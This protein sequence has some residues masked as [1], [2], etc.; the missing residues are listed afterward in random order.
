M[1]LFGE[2]LATDG[3]KDVRRDEMMLRWSHGRVPVNKGRSQEDV[4]TPFI[5]HSPVLLDTPTHWR[6]VQADGCRVC[7]NGLVLLL[8]QRL[9]HFSG[10]GDDYCRAVVG[11]DV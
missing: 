3:Q 10:G 11:A 1:H 6:F 7:H 5:A 2:K 8:V 4:H 9:I